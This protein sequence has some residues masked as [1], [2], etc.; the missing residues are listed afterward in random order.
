[1]CEKSIF[2]F[3]FLLRCEGVAVVVA[4]YKGVVS[5]F[6]FFAPVGR[7]AP[8]QFLIISK[9]LMC[10]KERNVLKDA[11][12][13]A[14]PPIDQKGRRK[15]RLRNS[16]APSG[17]TNASQWTIIRTTPFFSPLPSVK[18]RIKNR[19]RPI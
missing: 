14:T 8:I 18:I 6:S 1:M 12:M 7:L 5:L 15:R 11:E 16:L 17:P 10:K 2:L 4:V 9:N 19:P 13:M 3:L